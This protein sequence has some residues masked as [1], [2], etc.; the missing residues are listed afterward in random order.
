MVQLVAPG[1]EVFLRLQ[2]RLYRS[3]KN[4]VVAAN[5]LDVFLELQSS[6]TTSRLSPKIGPVIGL[7]WRLVA[8]GLEVL[9]IIQGSGTT[10]LLS[11]R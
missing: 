8:N 4:G 5:G 7:V 1:L 2:R 11:P 6:G 3:P 9:R 10:L